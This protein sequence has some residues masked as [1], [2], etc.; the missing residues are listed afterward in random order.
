MCW[1]KY[2]KLWHPLITEY[3]VFCTNLPDFWKSTRKVAMS[4]FAL[5]HVSAIMEVILQIFFWFF[6]LKNILKGGK[7]DDF[8]IYDVKFPMSEFA[9]HSN[10]N[11]KS[12]T[13]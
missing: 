5:P 2:Y 10:F 11:V 6:F 7:K 1:Y 3:D 12:S 4:E 9:L 8:D 13:A